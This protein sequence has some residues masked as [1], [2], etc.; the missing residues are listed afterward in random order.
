MIDYLIIMTI[1]DRVKLIKL[2]KLEYFIIILLKVV[3]V[4]L[5]HSF[6]VLI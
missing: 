1:N 5:V 2:G 6:V 3:T 4:A